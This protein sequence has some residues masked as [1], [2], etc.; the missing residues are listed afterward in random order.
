M[1]K[2]CLGTVQFGMR[3]GIYN[4][5]GQPTKQQSFRMLD[6]A[7][8][9]GIDIIDTAAAY[10]MAEELLGEYVDRQ[11]LAGKVNIISKLR[12][13]L[14]GE[15]CANP[16]QAVREQVQGSLKKLGV[17]CLEGYLLHTPANIYNP[18]IIEGLDRCREEGLIK[19]PG[20]SIYDLK[21]GFDAL[22]LPVID[23][24]Q[25]PYSIL[26]QRAAR[27]GF[28]AAAREREI[29][30]FTRSALIQGLILMEK[31]DVPGH[32]QAAIPY[33]EELEGI[34][35]D[36][37]I[38][39]LSAALLF[40]RDEPGIDYL[41]FGVDTEEQLIE[42]MTVLLHNTM[43]TTL[44]AEI[45]QHFNDMEQSIIIPSLWARAN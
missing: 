27:N 32:L 38:S 6:M 8:D 28:I 10:G 23:F 34:L 11:H 5:T 9:Y 41:V 25:V 3:Y 24:I 45:K 7:R 22:N 1:A 16:V 21:Q 12:P 26:D 37:G 18:G 43:P 17:D 40:A 33:L 4:R 2:L 36:Y 20:V 39:R 30:L 29:T 13:N 19:H 42:D 31:E 44:A 15:D 35:K 14:I